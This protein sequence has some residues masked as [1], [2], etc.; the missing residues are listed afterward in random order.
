[1]KIK[2]SDL[3]AEVQKVA[4]ER[5]DYVYDKL[6]SCS[7]TDDGKPSCIVGH[8]MSRL[9]V[10]MEVME[11]LDDGGGSGG[12]YVAGVP[13]VAPEWFDADSAEALRS[14]GVTQQLQ[15][16]GE[17]WGKAVAEAKS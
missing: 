11:M 12:T 16:E 7:Y 4:Q 13:E 15:D 17:S 6:E 10:P 14:L 9:G 8:G 5:P 3:W 1:M 2:M